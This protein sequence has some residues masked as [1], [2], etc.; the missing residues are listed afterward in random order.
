MSKSGHLHWFH[1]MI[2]SISLAATIAAW[3]F[4]Q[5]Q[6]DEKA[7]TRFRLATEQV[8]ALV[9]ERMEKY[10]D[11]LWGGVSTIQTHDG[12]I[13]HEN[14]R[15]FAT[16]LEID[17]KYP[18][19]NGIGVIHYVPPENL[20]EFLVSQR[21][22]RPDF[23][24]HPPHDREGYWPI[25]YVEPLNTNGAAIGL[26]MAHETNR[27]QAAQK[28]KD[29]GQAQITGPIV[30][31]ADVGQ[32]PG[33]LF[34]APYYAGGVYKT[35]EE[36]Q[37]HFSG[38]VYAPFVFHKLMEG[39]LNKANRQVRIK[40]QDG[41]DIL[42]DEHNDTEQSVNVNPLFTSRLDLEIYGRTWTFDVWT[43]KS[44]QYE[45]TNRQ[46]ILILFGGIVI[47]IMLLTLFVLLTR[48]NRRALAFADRMT[49]EL[50]ANA[51][52]LL[53]SNEELEK[54]AYVASHDLKSPLRGITHLIEFM[55]DDLEQYMATDAAN[56]DVRKNMDRMWDQA[57]R[58]ENLINGILEY[59]SIRG[60]HGKFE[61][62]D[63]SK[64]TANLVS[65]LGLRADQVVL[66]GT[67]PVL[68]T[69]AAQFEQVLSNLL[70]NAKKYHHQ[71]D[72]AL[73][74]VDVWETP[75]SHVFS[76]KDNGPGI[77]PRF[78]DRIFE[79]FQTLQPRDVIESTGI[80]LAIVKKILE[81]FGG[82]VKVVSE[83][84]DGSTF[85]F[86][87][88]KKAKLASEFRTGT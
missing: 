15:R 38:M 48:S 65:D 41:T 70:S 8:L 84:G 39:V 30:L 68:N 26:D 63:T 43:T 60:D 2:L 50:R 24:I 53:E 36:R 57:H 54:F 81:K 44:F 67:F 17:K 59:S 85:T 78:H 51:E 18:G 55:G 75:N 35:I 66:N 9:S 31:V 40:V 87:W 10:E 7:E 73:I 72:K 46:P 69:N 71:P 6:V 34:Y 45:L 88:P 25:T 47:D 76:I 23:T 4:T 83:P 42:Y 11:G 16:S 74:T 86:E 12:K 22:D 82:N 56:P 58:M 61:K 37:E 64:L 21:E 77:D 52:K 5:K 1:W 14:W 79:V 33:F 28:A 29:S 32:T 3:W 27:F 20:S 13:S 49:H 80:G 62:L 19:I